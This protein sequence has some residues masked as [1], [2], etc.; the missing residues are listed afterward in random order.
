[1]AVAI[2]GN[3]LNHAQFSYEEG[4]LPFSSTRLDAIAAKIGTTSANVSAYQITEGTIEILRIGDLKA[5]AVPVW[6]ADEITGISFSAAD[7]VKFAVGFVRTAGKAKES[8]GTTIIL[9]AGESV[10]VKAVIYNLVNGVPTTQ[11]TQAGTKL[12]PVITTKGREVLMPLV[13]TSGESPT[14]VISADSSP[15]KIGEYFF[16]YPNR[17]QGNYLTFPTTGILR[18][19]RTLDT[20]SV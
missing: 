14:F 6:T 17:S 7:G 10:T 2:F 20:A 16:P 15:D 8:D 3:K 5:I 18:I 19:V 11:S 1:M 12:V 9:N 4:I 13:F